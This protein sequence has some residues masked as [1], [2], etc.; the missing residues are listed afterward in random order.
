MEKQCTG[1]RESST[2]TGS[3][4]CII[5]SAPPNTFMNLEQILRN[6]ELSRI[7]VRVGQYLYLLKKRKPYH[8]D[9]THQ[10]KGLDLGIQKLL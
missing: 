2:Y 3:D 8:M 9:P 5:R 4:A 10:S 6:I 7:V 1:D